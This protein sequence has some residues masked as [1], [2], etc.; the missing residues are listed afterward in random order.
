MRVL[1]QNSVTVMFHVILHVNAERMQQMSPET[2]LSGDSALNLVQQRKTAGK[3]FV[4]DEESK[5]SLLDVELQ[6]I[7]DKGP[8]LALLEVEPQWFTD[9]VQELQIEAN[10][11]TFFHAKCNAGTD[12]RK[13]AM[14]DSRQEHGKCRME[15]KTVNVANVTNNC[16]DEKK[17][18]CDKMQML[19]E[20]SYCDHAASQQAYCSELESCHAAAN[21][22]WAVADK[23]VERLVGHLRSLFI[24]R[25]HLEC[26]V[27]AWP[28]TASSKKACEN[29]SPDTS[30]LKVTYPKKPTPNP[31][32]YPVTPVPGDSIWSGSE[33]ADKPWKDLVLPVKACTT[34]TTTTAPPPITCYDSLR[35]SERPLGEAI[36]VTKV[37]DCL[38]HV[39]GYKYMAF[40]CPWRK[41]FECWRGNSINRA[42]KVREMTQCKGGAPHAPCSGYPTGTYTMT[43]KGVSLPLGGWCKEPVM[44]VAWIKALR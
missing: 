40:G 43:Y 17:K 5:A 25:A 4:T 31:C 36:Y 11:Q 33:Y 39:E 41:G 6:Q 18:T 21:A 8:N 23:H 12:P 1:S 24:L 15:E 38:A 35:G 32:V 9:K 42:A 28:V 7:M 19:F 27:A 3:I 37:S 22:A 26:Q 30:H 14:D 16:K 44:D 20:E 29:L 34:T 13:K 2:L 10:N